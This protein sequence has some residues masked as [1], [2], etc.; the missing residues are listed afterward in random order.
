MSG[1]SGDSGLPQSMNEHNEVESSEPCRRLTFVSHAGEDKLFARSLLDAIEAANVATFFDDDMAVGTP[2]GDEMTTRAAKADKGV[3]VLSR[4]FLTKKWPM[5][6]LNLFVKNKI[7]IHPLYYGVCPDELQGILDTYDRQAGDDELAF[8]LRMKE[9]PSE[10]RKLMEE[11]AASTRKESSSSL[12]DPMCWRKDLR[13]LSKLTGLRRENFGGDK[14]N[15]GDFENAV[16]KMVAPPVLPGVIPPVPDHFVN[17]HLV[18]D[19][20]SELLGCTMNTGGRGVVLTGMGGA[21]KSVI[22]SA[23]VRDK[24]IRRHFTDGVLWLDQEPGEYNEELFLLKLNKLAQ[25]FEEVVLSRHYRQGRH[26]QYNMGYLT[27]VTGAQ[28]LFQMWQTKYNLRCL[29]VVDNAWDVQILEA[30]SLMGFQILATTRKEAAIPTCPGW[31]SHA[32]ARMDEDASLRVLQNCS[33]APSAVPRQPA[34][35]VADTCAFLPLALAIIGSTL[36]GAENPLSPNAW[37]KLQRKLKDRKETIHDEGEWDPLNKVLAVS[38]DELGQTRRELFLMLAVLGKGVLASAEMLRNLW[39]EKDL[40]GARF[41][42]EGLVT[43]SLLQ[44][45]E[46]DNY[47]VHD[48]LLDFAKVSIDAKAENREGI[49]EAATSRQTQYLGRLDVLEDYSAN[50]EWDSREGLY[51]LIGLWRSLEQLSGDEHLEVRAYTASLGNLLKQDE[52]ES[53]DVASICSDLGHLYV[54]QGKLTDAEPVFE[55]SQ[56]IIEKV[57]GPDHPKMAESLNNRAGLFES[58][59]MYGEADQLYLRAIE[60]GEKAL[61][62]ESPN[63]ALWLSNRAGLLETKGEYAKAEPLYRRC[64]AIQERVL[65]PEHPSFA[66]TLNSWATLLEDQGKYDEAEPLFARAI[67]IGEMALGRDHPQVA[68]YLNNRAGLLESQGKYDE[69]D[70]LYAKA[71]AIGEKSLGREHLDVA[72]WLNNQAGLWDSQGNYEESEPLYARSQAIREKVLGPEHPDVAQS[73]NNRAESLREQGE[74]KLADPL[75]LRAI[76]IWEVAQGSDH[77]NVATALHNRALLLEDQGLVAEAE[78]LY[79]K[80]RAIREM[81]LGPEHP[82]VAAS[83]DSQA[84]L[85]KCQGN[86][87]DAKT[88]FER[89]T[90]IWE[91]VHGLDHPLVATGFNNRAGVLEA[92]GNFEE[93]GPLYVRAIEIGENTLG[94][95]HPE[96][97][98]FLNNWAGLLV[99]QGKYVQ[100]EPLF[101]RSRA[102]REGVLGPEHPDVPQSLNDRAGLLSICS[103]QSLFSDPLYKRAIVI[104]EEALGSEDPQVATGLNNRAW[105]LRMQGKYREAEPLYK[106]S[107]AIDEEEYG[108]DHSEVATDLSNWA[109]LMET[110]EKYTEAIPLLERALKIRMN[111]LGEIH[112]DTV[113]TRNSLEIVRKRCDTHEAAACHSCHS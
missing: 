89:A 21:G 64:Q 41:F 98:T 48:L 77:P 39:G 3:V 31:H 14:E 86:Y 97:A 101:E 36:R 76:K 71:I 27:S 72:V 106:R 23:V 53:K 6:E 103:S 1:S 87:A 93:A 113:S 25:Q 35:E 84:C 24:R 49:K 42:V 5:M 80:S 88:L 29:L 59:G 83:L 62:P 109:D 73:L 57:L 51:S 26:V 44:R 32:V 61:G 90:S 100:A 55:A 45:R 33:G 110:Q 19:V 65:G 2:A 95:N 111:N 28:R 58:K 46:A 38:I 102:L 37:R 104:W 60:I 79:E 63:L 56:G 96:V 47:F 107:L 75:S 78:S 68:R 92:L 4:P 50:R 112:P 11:V 81:K 85:L 108:P 16:A 69:A 99:S 67:A 22:A 82:D 70:M 105:L 91:K 8:R 9:N 66:I 17:V 12:P 52:Q 94:P 15:K 54:L 74:Y 34:L 10:W 40:E 20:I 43:R 30:A 13:E 18:D 7:R